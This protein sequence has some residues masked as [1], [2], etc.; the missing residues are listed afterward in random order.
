MLTALM[1]KVKTY[2]V[3]WEFQLREGNYEKRK[4]KWNATNE[5]HS[6]DEN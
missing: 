1:R 3:K 4:K 5:K 6:I 2:N